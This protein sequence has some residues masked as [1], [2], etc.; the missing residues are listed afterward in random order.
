MIIS[1][2][3]I[4]KTIG[5]RTRRACSELADASKLI[6][7]DVEPTSDALPNKCVLNVRDVVNNEGG[8]VVL[9]W[10]I[11]LWPDVMIQCIGHAVHKSNTGLRC[12]TP[13][14]DGCERIL[15]LPDS[16]LTFD[17]DDPQARLPTK[18]IPLCKDPL[19]AR[20]IE[21]EE[22]EYLIK[23]RYPRG[24]DT[25][26]VRGN[27]A[28]ELRRLDEAKPELVRRVFLR[29]KHHNDTCVCGSGRKFRKCCR[30]KMLAV[31]PA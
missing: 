13:D 17:F 25:I 4:P 8:E 27:D 19:V 22:R 16:S 26:E 12:V 3:K 28:I 20:L 7:V 1:P 15:F 24:A 5:V 18:M 2:T 9:G 6:F 23:C 29:T 10:S 14:K 21:N 11:S 30:P 31:G